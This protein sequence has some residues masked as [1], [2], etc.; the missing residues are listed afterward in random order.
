MSTNSSNTNRRIL[1]G[2]V[3]GVVLLGLIAAIL[4]GFFLLPRLRDGDGGTTTPILVNTPVVGRSEGQTTTDISVSYSGSDG[5]EMGG[6]SMTIR[7]S[8]GQAMPEIIQEVPP[9][10]G[11]PLSQAEIDRILDRLPDL[12]TEPD[13]QV[14]FNLPEESPPA[15]RTG[16]TIDE[17]FPPA[18]APVTPAE[19]DSGPL[20][21][22]RF[23]PEGEIP[24]APFV[25]VTFNQPMV[26]LDTL[27][28]LADRKSVV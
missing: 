26:A 2:A 9:A 22:L 8:E 3:G 6:E 24:L 27:E 11:E 12:T 23:S 7:L 13:D 18:P 15:P 21:V 10:E 1:I 17:P 20:E 5:E 25:S 16:E 19:V 14:D 28:S 4:G